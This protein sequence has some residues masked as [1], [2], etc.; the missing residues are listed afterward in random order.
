MLLVWIVGFS[1]LGSVGAVA[2]A[3]VF[4][5]LP[6]KT[7]RILIPCLVSYAAGTL[8]AAAF[9]GLIPHALT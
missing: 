6:E 4:L 3:G 9:L 8:P 2:L 7:R 1:L 5:L